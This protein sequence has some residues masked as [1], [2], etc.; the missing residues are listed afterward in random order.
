MFRKQPLV[1]FSHMLMT[2]FQDFE[3][4]RE[5]CMA[6]E[7]AK[8]RENQEPASTPWCLTLASLSGRPFAGASMHFCAR[9]SRLTPKFI[10]S[11]TAIF[12]DQ[13]FRYDV[14]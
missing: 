4:Q 3:E 6:V 9:C 10:S 14:I 13:F 8:E 7:E 12:F 11:V 2:S 5:V 1:N